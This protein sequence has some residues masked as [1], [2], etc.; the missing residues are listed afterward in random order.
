MQYLASIYESIS[1]FLI[2]FYRAYRALLDLGILYA[3][4]HR[5][6]LWYILQPP[7]SGLLVTS[8]WGLSACWLL[9]RKNIMKLLRHGI[10]IPVASL[11][12]FYKIS[13]TAAIR[14]LK[15]SVLPRFYKKQHTMSVNLSSLNDAKKAAAYK[16]VDQHVKVYFTYFIL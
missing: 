5:A 6:I 15:K 4:F 3:L 7:L 12:T 9:C 14:D 2:K 16:A 13:T 1:P 10:A 8:D 11:A